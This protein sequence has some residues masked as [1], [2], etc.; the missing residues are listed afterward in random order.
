MTLCDCSLPR[1]P[2]PS[3]VRIVTLAASYPLRL[4]SYRRRDAR[5]GFDSLSFE[6]LRHLAS[7]PPAGRQSDQ[8]KQRRRPAGQK[9]R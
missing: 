5:V 8:T 1:R 6:Q 4:L 3:I 9:N 7:P 2:V